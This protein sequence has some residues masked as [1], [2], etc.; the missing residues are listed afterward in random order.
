M[1]NLRPSPGS[2]P[3]ARL[4]LQTA[5]RCD[6]DPQRLI[7]AFAGQR[8]R[9][10]TALEGFGAD[11]WAAPT[12]C[13]DWSAQEV[14]RHLCDANAIGIAIGP[15]DAMLD[16][17]EGFDPRT[18]PRRW[19]ASS[20]GESPGATL[21]RFTATTSEL[22][23]LARDRLAQGRRFDVR[24]PYG[25]MDW[26]VLLLHG[27]WD[28]WI[29]ERDVLLARGEAHPTDGAATAYAAAYGLFIAATV[30]AMFGSQVHEKLTLSGDGGGAFEVDGRA[31]VTFTVL[32]ATSAG[33]CAA[34]VADAVAGRAPL[35]AALPG[36]P[37]RSRAALSRMADF[38]HTPAGL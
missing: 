31:G 37:G 20:A 27:F 5:G 24:L 10:V 12:R 1:I 8:R 34:E 11:D 3:P 7:A 32:P 21:D 25:P 30:A 26:T 35:A 18:S 38:F 23:S 6:V 9:F 22:L 19:L 15:D 33:P 29:H 4:L 14:V 28:S 17:T 13:A 36:L 16:V 2:S